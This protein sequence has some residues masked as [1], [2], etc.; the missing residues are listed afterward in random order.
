M[1]P[2]SSNNVA[3]LQIDNIK[4]N[5][6]KITKPQKQK[7]DF[8]INQKDL[9]NKAIDD[10]LLA[11]KK[12][13]E[14]KEKQDEEAK[15]IKEQHPLRFCIIHKI[16]YDT[17]E[18]YITHT[19]HNHPHIAIDEG[20]ANFQCEHCGDVFIRFSNYKTHFDQCTGYKQYLQNSE[21]LSARQKY[22]A[23]QG[24]QLRRSQF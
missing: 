16:L 23:K 10:A 15:L 13:K 9:E 17:Q 4:L 22:L 2:S 21:Q 19:I 11:E 24:D 1:Q 5:K 6:Y 12:I 7:P 3:K 18:Q 20:L 14:N 8:S